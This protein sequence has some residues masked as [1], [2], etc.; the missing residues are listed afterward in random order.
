M[1]PQ[2]LMTIEA[3]AFA[4]TNATI[5]IIPISV[6]TIES[7]AF[8]HCTGLQILYFE[9]SPFSI[10]S[11]I[12]EGCENVTVSVVKGRSAEKWAIRYGYAVNY[13]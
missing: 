12:L 8:A 2:G 7:R 13:H 6:D 11:D 1:V 5:I 3:E 4:G 9:G 10:S